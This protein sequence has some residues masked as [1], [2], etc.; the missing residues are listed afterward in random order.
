MRNLPYQ[1]PY[2][3]EFPSG[4]ESSM[5]V[6]TVR[7][8]VEALGVDLPEAPTVVVSPSPIEGRP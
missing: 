3:M 5:R 6:P 8:P 7:G 4:T 1:S 2:D